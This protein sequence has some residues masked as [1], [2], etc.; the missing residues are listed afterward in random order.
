MCEYICLSMLCFPCPLLPVSGDMWYS[1]ICSQSLPSDWFACF[2]RFPYASCLAETRQ[3]PCVFRTLTD[4]VMVAQL[5]VMTTQNCPPTPT[6]SLILPCYCF[7]LTLP[8]NVLCLVQA[9]PHR[10]EQSP[11]VG[12][13]CLHP[14]ITSCHIRSSRCLQILFLS[15]C[16][17]LHKSFKQQLH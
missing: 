9:P 13:R 15:A 8:A 17:H 14:I 5:V 11:G 4:S 2:E 1:W 7:N 6:V 16:E 12:A 10:N 3:L